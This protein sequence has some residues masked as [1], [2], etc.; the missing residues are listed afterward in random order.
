[1]RWLEVRP[2]T[3]IQRL[4]T[5][6]IRRHL[7]RTAVLLW[8]ACAAPWAAAATVEYSVLSQ[9]TV[10]GHMTV[11]TA[12]DGSVSVDYSYRDNGRGPDIRE[13]Y[14]PGP[15]AAPLS[16]K[17]AGTSTFGAEIRESFA[18][19]DGRL[20]WQSRIDRG[21]EPAPEGVLFLPLES[22][23]AYTGQLVRSLLQRP[24]LA[25]P[26]IGG[27]KLVAQKL[28]T[29]TLAASGGPLPVVLVAVTGADSEP[30]YLW[31][32]DDGSDAFFGMLYPGWAVLPKGL[33]SSAAPMLARQTQAQ[34]ERLMALQRQ[35]ARPL[36]GLT[37]IRAVRWFD[38][39][40]A[41]MRGPSDIWLFGGR[42][43]A[44][45]PPG[46]LRVPAD[47]V[48]DGAGRTLLPGLFDMHAHLW[49]GEAL[50]HLAGGVTSVRDMGNENAML[51]TLKSRIDAGDLPGPNIFP[52]G[53]IEGKSAFSARNGFVVD[54]LD[55]A[56]AAVDW[57]AARGYRQIKLY[58]SIHPEWV[59]PLAAHAHQ[60]GLRVAGHV[61][62]FMRAEQA[63]R[64]GY[65]ELTHINQV[66]LNFVVRPGDD[67]RTLE[68]FTRIGED[69]GSLDLGS[70]KARAF[71]RLL[72]ERGTTVDPTVGTFES[73]FT[74]AQ[75]QP[76]PGLA[77][78]ADHLPAAWRRGL[79]VAEMDLDGAKLAT[80]RRSFQRLLDL[81]VAMQRAGVPLVAGTDA[82]AG[83]GLHR[84]LALYVQ[85]GI[86]APQALQTATWNAAR[87][88]GEGDRRGS[89][90]R[91]KM[92][93][94]LLVDGDPG[95]NITDL[96]RASLVIKG[97]VAY[98]PSA[99]YEAM[100]FKPFV[101]AAAVLATPPP[102]R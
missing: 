30:W 81:T 96:R 87:V 9:E 20:R 40:A 67:T 25:S 59:K 60:H 72:R 15:L 48:V 34:D 4:C 89:I 38:A 46:A 65:D 13:Q 85:A 64:D 44:V 21:D 82:L 56:K 54:S 90:E 91:G 69:A 77:D 8:L 100:G 2:A 12:A 57:Y 52:A 75:G 49:S 102:T 71:L 94:L 53:F 76:D 92:A 22:S 78:I 24:G 98:S 10:S 23:P 27:H 14:L 83:L 58:N 28:A 95:V 43:S 16:F 19:T 17:V 41:V 5:A 74:Q 93:D 26:V 47:Q 86:P 29:L 18:V 66:M 99:L 33:E 97:G 50:N 51:L 63:V 1:M 62:A 68:R 42:I 39:K 7:K 6:A 36:P 79:K 80:F 61:P 3:R 11:E 88:A 32:R 37:L 73:M 31:L 84:E 45:T 101:V 55:A 35:L 70:P